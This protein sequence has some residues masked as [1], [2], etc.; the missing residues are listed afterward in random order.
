MRLMIALNLILIGVLGAANGDG[1]LAQEL[2]AVGVYSDERMSATTVNAEA[3]DL[4]T[5]YVVLDNPQNPHMEDQANSLVQNV[6]C[7]S[8]A[9]DLTT[10]LELVAKAAK[11][12][13]PDCT[14]VCTEYRNCFGFLKPVGGDRFITLTSFDLRYLGSGQAEIRLRAPE[15]DVIEGEMDFWYRDILQTGWILP[16]YPASGSFDNPVF[17]VNGDQVPATKASWGS[18]K[19]IYR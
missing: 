12:I 2:N 14:G 5:V 18:L 10:N 15:V 11:P 19:S 1:L 7:Y 8:F 17:V 13:R 6:G 9:L 3:G 16:M 4:L